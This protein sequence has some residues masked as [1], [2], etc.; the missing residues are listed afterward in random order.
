MSITV[1]YSWKKTR[2]I[3]S[4]ATHVK[5]VF[6]EYINNNSPLFKYLWNYVCG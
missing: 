6:F 4:T 2:N 5:I 3:Y 1:C